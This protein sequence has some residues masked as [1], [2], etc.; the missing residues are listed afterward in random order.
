[1]EILPGQPR[2]TFVPFLLFIIFS[3]FAAFGA[4]YIFFSSTNNQR[5]QT[6]TIRLLTIDEVSQQNAISGGGS[7]LSIN[8]STLID[9]PTLSEILGPEDEN[10]LFLHVLEGYELDK[11]IPI[12]HSSSTLIGTRHITGTT[13]STY[14]FML[15]NVFGDSSDAVL[16]KK[17]DVDECGLPGVQWE[18]LSDKSAVIV[19][20][21]Q[22][23]CEGDGIHTMYYFADDFVEKFKI[24]ETTDTSTLVLSFTDSSTTSTISLISDNDC[25]QLPYPRETG[26]EWKD[27]N[28]PVVNLLGL[29]VVRTGEAGNNE[30]MLTFSSP[31]SL[32]CEVG[33]GDSKENPSIK[34]IKYAEGQLLFGFNKYVGIIDLDKIGDIFEHS[35]PYG[36]SVEGVTLK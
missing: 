16:V 26:K 6:D 2:N 30:K 29:K 31:I 13:S 33:Y 17:L 21:W 7:V 3:I 18:Y 5:A 4:A 25:T 12:P 9:N 11:I 24:V 35:G 1:M 23:S 8:T 15:W 14:S 10:G 34:L 22:R 19:N 32:R 27:E 36:I 20:Y 28:L